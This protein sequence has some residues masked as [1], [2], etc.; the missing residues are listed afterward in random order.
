MFDPVDP[1]EM[2]FALSLF[3]SAGSGQISAGRKPL[4]IESRKAGETL[5]LS[6]VLSA[7]ER[8]KQQPVEFVL[9]TKLFESFLLVW[10][11]YRNDAAQRSIGARILGFYRITAGSKGAAL[12]RW[13]T[14][15]ERDESLVVLNPAVVE[16]LAR[17]EL[18]P[19]GWPEEVSLL[20]A[21]EGLEPV[22]IVTTS[23][24]L[25]DWP[26]ETGTMA[27]LLRQLDWSK[28]PLGPTE[29][30]SP[31]LKSVVQLA[32]A[33]RFPMIV[34]WGK[35][36]TQIYNDG[37]CDLMGSKHPRGFG[38]AT[39]DCWPEVWHI[40]APIYERVFQGETLTFEDSLYPIHR[41]GHLEDAYFTL[42]YS[43]LRNEDGAV[44]G[45]LVTVFETTE[46]V[47]AEMK[48]ETV[49]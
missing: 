25:S 20:H 42:C 8:S 5:F 43:P 28:T 33:C 27:L 47:C 17:V 3:V 11:H 12:Q 1:D 23:S 26:R 36:L 48:T 15:N 16:G 24:D 31:S 21:I 14:D 45:V 41:H 34:L 39:R 37:Y 40:N 30:W 38:Q 29:D 35:E 49:L 44:E 46:R 18:S 32:L 7:S 6:L 9:G 2:A 13:I 19:N 10:E 4:T 22:P